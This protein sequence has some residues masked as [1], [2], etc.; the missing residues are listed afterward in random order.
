MILL[1]TEVPLLS[2][3][4]V[5]GPIRLVQPEACPHGV[6]TK[7]RLADKHH[8]SKAY[9]LLLHHL[10]AGA[11]DREVGGLRG[12]G[13]GWNV[14]GVAA[15]AAGGHVQALARGDLTGGGRAQALTRGWGRDLTGVGSRR[16]PRRMR[17]R[18]RLVHVFLG[19]GG[20]VQGEKGSQK[21]EVCVLG[22]C[23]CLNEGRGREPRPRHK[24]W[25]VL[26]LHTPAALVSYSCAVLCVWSQSEG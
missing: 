17:G 10:D 2:E 5:V 15:A 23:L 14:D 19:C 3:T 1:A 12:L 26:P 18:G 9:V 16:S 25:V 24:T 21:D 22:V 8:H 20:R 13:K 7:V 6:R 4:A 11:D